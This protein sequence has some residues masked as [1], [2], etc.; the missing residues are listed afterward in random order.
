MAQEPRARRLPAS[1]TGPLRPTVV[2]SAPLTSLAT[3]LAHART[4]HDVLTHL[5]HQALEVTGGSCALLFERNP[6]TGALHA[7]SGYAVTSLDA[8]PWVLTEADATI[9]DDLF[10]QG[11]PML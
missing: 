11:G 4:L 9:V 6:R 7:T 8:E 2:T 3:R 10:A 5:H 1:G